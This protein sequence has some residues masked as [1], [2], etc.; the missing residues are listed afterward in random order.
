M[1]VAEHLLHVGHILYHACI[2]IP[3]AA[4]LLFFKRAS[5]HQSNTTTYSQKKRHVSDFTT[6]HLAK[7]TLKLQVK[8][9]H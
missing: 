9:N 8:Y 7:Y 2:N 1:A 4:Q 6:H 3:T 5:Y